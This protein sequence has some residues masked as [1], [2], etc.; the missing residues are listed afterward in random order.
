[1]SIPKVVMGVE[2]IEQLKIMTK[3][4]ES[5]S[6]P[7]AR[8]VAAELIEVFKIEELTEKQ[9]DTAQFLVEFLSLKDSANRILYAIGGA[10]Q[11]GKEEIIKTYNL[12]LSIGYDD[13]KIKDYYNKTAV[14]LTRD[15]ASVKEQY[16]YLVKI[17]FTDEEINDCFL[18]AI[19]LGKEYMLSRC[20]L[21]LRYFN[22]DLL[23]QLAKGYLFY[24]YFNDPEDCI[25]YIV[26]FLGKEK[27]EQVLRGES[28]L[29]Y[30]WKSK[31]YRDEYVLGNQHD[32]AMYIIKKYI[33]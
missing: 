1:M 31:F 5:I 22:K 15:Y 4:L 29:L 21:V 14:V 26:N 8:R 20:E 33:N 18:Y 13:K 30:L 7:E 27:A 19:S 28:E 2:Y 25:E 23:V 17:G 10:I 3:Q 9:V 32:E 24:F 11:N 6:F 12:L 16:D